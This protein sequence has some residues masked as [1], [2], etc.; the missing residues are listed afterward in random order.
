MESKTR[1]V[2]IALVILATV[3][4]V[5]FLIRGIISLV[6]RKPS[7]PKTSN[8]TLTAAKPTPITVNP[9]SVNKD[10]L[11]YDGLS[12]EISSRVSDWITKKIFA[13]SAGTSSFFGGSS[14]QLIIISED[15]FPLHKTTLEKG[16]GLG[17]LVNVKIKG[18]VRI[19]DRDELERITGIDL[20]GKDI[21][22]DDNP[23]SKW[24]EGPVVLLDSVEKL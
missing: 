22:L 13:V 20:D 10:P 6:S 18:R 7:E 4:A 16:L 2:V 14:G 24:K 15:T 12:V 21:K 8:S 3:L 17:E 19:V 11:I 1:I 9:A 23:I 5:I